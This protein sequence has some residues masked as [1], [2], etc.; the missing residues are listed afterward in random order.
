MTLNV[1]LNNNRIPLGIPMEHF[2]LFRASIEF[3]V[4]I[5]NLGKKQLKGI[6]YLTSH[7]IIFVS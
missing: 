2:L 5:D 3:E 4:K 6:A 7:R 1:P